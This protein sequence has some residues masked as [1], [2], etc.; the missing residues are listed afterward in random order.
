[1]ELCDAQSSVGFRFVE[2]EHSGKSVI[3]DDSDQGDLWIQ[4]ET[5]HCI[6]VKSC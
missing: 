6:H 5:R 1:M 2:Y 3:I 4:G